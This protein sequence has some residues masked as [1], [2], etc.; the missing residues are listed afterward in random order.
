MNADLLD[1]FDT[2]QRMGFDLLAATA[3]TLE[4]GMTE[5]DLD[6]VARSKAKAMGF[7]GWFHPPEIQFGARSKSNAVWKVPS[8]TNRLSKGDLVVLDF[9]PALGEAYA[10]AG[11]TL[12][13][14]VEETPV[15]QVARD[16]ARATCGFS[17]HWKTVGELLVFA[18]AWANNNRLTLGSTRSIGHAI[19]PKE[20]MLA[21]NFPRSAHAATWLRR[22]QI[23]FLNPAKLEGMWAIRP[24]ITDG[25]HGAAFEEMIFVSQD[26][27][28]VMGRDNLSQ[29][30]SLPS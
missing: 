5:A 22:H 23:R 21:F 26:G 8:K 27:C 30:G 10:D 13:F 17:S 1:Q 20:G 25:T 4:A 29:I 15:V 19:L 7:E 9:G 28:R 6:D 24:L 2:A 12:A 14:G 11:T 3:A 18:K 16:C